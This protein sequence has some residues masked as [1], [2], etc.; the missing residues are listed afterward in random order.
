MA[1]AFTA[2]WENFSTLY[3][4]AVSFISLFFNNFFLGSLGGDFYKIYITGKDSD[5]KGGPA[6]SVIMDRVTGVLILALMTSISGIVI[7]FTGSSLISSDNVAIIIGASLVLL[8]TVF[9][10]FNI[11]FRVSNLSFINKFPRFAEIVE[12]I[13][14]STKLYMEH[15]KIILASL[16]LS[17]IYYV[18]ASVTMYFYVLAAGQNLNF[19]LLLF[20]NMIVTFLIMIPVSLNGIGVQEGAFVFYLTKLGIN[21]ASSLLIALLPRIDMLIFSLIGA[22]I[23]LTEGGRKSK[24]FTQKN[25]ADLESKK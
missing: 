6:S 4:C 2:A 15:P 16:G 10:G 7:Y 20:I 19:I 5:S 17:F 22:V 14:V 11:F 13:I 3:I 12:S 24:L 23:Y 9:T 18:I 21:P 25:V 1:S 8:L